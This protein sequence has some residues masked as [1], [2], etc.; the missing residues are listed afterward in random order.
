MAEG[1][2]VLHMQLLQ[3]K[4]LGFEQFSAIATEVFRKAKNGEEY[5][6]AVRSLG[7]HIQLLN[8]EL[9]AELGFHSVV[10]VGRLDPAVCRVWDSGGASFQITAIGI[11]QSYL[12]I[13]DKYL[14]HHKIY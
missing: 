7:I 4:A 3:A 9:E 14:I 8:Q 11:T 10:S 6:E 5:L 13:I 1:L 2:A 12:Y